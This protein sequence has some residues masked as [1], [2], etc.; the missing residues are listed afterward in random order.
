M[1]KKYSQ[2][3]KEA[4]ANV[5]GVQ[6]FH[7]YLLGHKFMLQTDHEPLRTLFSESVISNQSA[8]VALH[9]MLMAEGLKDVPIT[10][11]Q[12]VQR[13]RHDP[14][15]ARVTRCLLEG[16][17]KSSHKELQPYWTRQLELSTD[18]E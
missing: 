6:H 8:A 10:A 7:A 13:T 4:L 18:D 2:I 3:E 5:Y 1:E 16:W 11:S 14:L 9:T 15:M 17:P 12:I